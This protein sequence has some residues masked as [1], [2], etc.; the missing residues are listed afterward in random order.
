MHLMHRLSQHLCKHLTYGRVPA[1]GSYPEIARIVTRAQ[2]AL[3]I[4]PFLVEEIQVNCLFIKQ[5]VCESPIVL[6]IS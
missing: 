4:T 6:C 3:T 1:K 2:Q 5:K